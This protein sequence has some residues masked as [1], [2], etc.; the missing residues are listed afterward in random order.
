[1]FG[2]LLFVVISLLVPSTSEAMIYVL[3]GLG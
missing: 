2:A 3:G 1:M